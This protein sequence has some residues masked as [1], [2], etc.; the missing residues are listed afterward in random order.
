MARLRSL[1]EGLGNGLGPWGEGD[2]MVDLARLYRSRLTSFGLAL[3]A[4]VALAVLGALP[5][6]AGASS[7]ERDLER[8]LDAA[9]EKAAAA[10]G[11]PGLQA[12]VMRNGRLL[13]SANRGT[14]IVEPD[15]PVTDTTLFCLGSFGKLMLSSYALRQV[16]LGRL[17]LDAPISTYVGDSVAGSDVVTTRMLLTHTA[18]YPDMYSSPEIG[19]LFGDQYDP[20]RAWTFEILAAGI[21]DPVDPTARWEYSNTGFIVLAHVL[22]TISRRPL[23]SAYIRF[24]RPAGAV[25][26]IDE[27]VLTMRRSHRALKRIAHGYPMRDGVFRDYFEGADGIPTDLYGM[28]FG[29]GAFAG[30]AL[31]G[32]QVLDGL[33]VR[34]RLLGRSTVRQM[35]TPTSQSLAAGGTY[36]MGTQRYSAG[37]R[38]WQGHSGSWGGF[39]AFGAT[40]ISRGVSIFVAANRQPTGHRPANE[41]WQALAEAYAQGT[42]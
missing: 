27:D 34:G 31:G 9:V 23:E 12:V 21:H 28:P 22:S 36:G 26:R 13:W 5:A 18:G 29:D 33:F 41:V 16:E 24:I 39:T 8:R 4:V 3:T 2:A 35:I 10:A 14:A 17:D 7:G 20:N 37:G 1:A 30:T 6:L 25:Q 32:A 40:D 15:K 11:E 19:P 42:N 38:S